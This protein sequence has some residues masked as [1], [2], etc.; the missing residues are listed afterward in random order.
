MSYPEAM[1]ADPWIADEPR[2][3]SVA[4]RVLRRGLR[5]PG[6]IFTFAVVATAGY[7]AARLAKA[8]VHE[9]T[10]YFRLTE[11]ELSDPTHGPRPSP[12]I[13]QHIWEVSLSRTQL[14]RIMG[15]FRVSQAWLARDPVAA[16][17]AFRDDI[18]LDVLRNDFLLDRSP[19]APPREATVT[20]TLAGVDAE[21]TR[22]LVH[23][24]G[25]TILRD[26]ATH[27]TARLDAAR[28]ELEARLADARHRAEALQRD[29]GELA[30]RARAAGNR[31]DRI[32]L[33]ARLSALEVQ[34]RDAAEQEGAVRRRLAD[35]AFTG[36]AEAE[37]LGFSF[38][39]LDERLVTFSPRLSPGNLA[40]RG[41]LVFALVL[42]L[43][44]TVAGAFD[45]RV[46]APAD[47][48]GCGLPVLGVLPAFPGDDAGSF[49]AR[50]SP[51]TARP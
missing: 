35:V 11:G 20:L 27:R 21:R 19:E 32:G 1:A 43:A 24:L 34:A 30:A 37:Q 15:Q 16:V 4:G 7:V 36:A 23:E 39:L 47:V 25:D 38:E 13:R 14:V 8:P 17:D 45:D 29:F 40:L 12:D 46:H 42:V 2:L 3:L 5:R 9:A 48:A 10:L 18:E 33:E 49:R 44:M 28:T 26:Q 50:A 31:V 6:L 51:R 41:V 22:A